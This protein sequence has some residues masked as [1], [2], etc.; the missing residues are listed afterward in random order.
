MSESLPATGFVRYSQIKD[1][2]PLSRA[3]LWRK[4]ADNTFPAPL[5]LSPGCVAWRVEDVRAWMAALST[6]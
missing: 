5:K 1:I 6:V 4:V 3:T 2:I